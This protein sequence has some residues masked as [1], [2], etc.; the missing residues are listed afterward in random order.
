MEQYAAVNA[1]AGAHG[2]DPGTLLRE[3]RDIGEMIAKTTHQPRPPLPGEPALNRLLGADLPLAAE[4]HL[5]RVQL[6]ARV[7]E[8]DPDLP[9]LWILANGL[10]HGVPARVMLTEPAHSHGP[11]ARVVPLHADLVGWHGIRHAVAHLDATLHSAVEG[12]RWL[13]TASDTAPNRLLAL[14]VINLSHPAPAHQLAR[15]GPAMA[16]IADAR[17]LADALPAPGHVVDLTDEALKAVCDRNNWLLGT[18]DERTGRELVERRLP[19]AV[20]AEVRAA[21]AAGDTRPLTVAIVRGT[22][23]DTDLDA[24][25][26]RRNPPSL[27]AAQ[28]RQLL[29]VASRE[30]MRRFAGLDIQPRPTQAAAIAARF[31]D[32]VARH[33]LNVASAQL[34]A[35][36]PGPR[37]AARQAELDLGL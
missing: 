17:A 28:R 2:M 31:P 15:D 10:H 16:E 29:D 27:E 13:A 19:D 22:P 32:R 5:A 9:R 24:A 36:E 34:L 8:S 3:A 7:A 14:G 20:T 11:L 23:A 33:G 4:L 18:A 25:T 12:R 21:L 30:A 26:W 37:P 35:G 6:T 1:V